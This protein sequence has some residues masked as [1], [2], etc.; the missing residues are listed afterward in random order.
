MINKK[1]LLA[2]AAQIYPLLQDQELTP[3]HGLIA[4]CSN[5]EVQQRLMSTLRACGA[6]QIHIACMKERYLRN[7]RLH[8]GLYQKSLKE[9]KIINFLDDVSVMKMLVGTMIPE[10]LCGQYEN[11]LLIFDESVGESS[12]VETAQGETK[13]FAAYARKNPAVIFRSMKLFKQ[14][15]ADG[16]ER[17]IVLMF[18]A[19]ACAWCEYL[20][21]VTEQQQVCQEKE[22][23][24]HLIDKWVEMSEGYL[25]FDLLG[26]NIGEMFVSYVNAHA[27]ILIGEVD[28]VD[29]AMA[30]AIEQG[31][32]IL[33]NRECFFV[34]EELLREACM[35]LRDAVS[36]LAIKRGLHEEGYLLCN[37]LKNGNYTTKLLVTNV[38]GYTSRPRFLKLKKEL[39]E[40]AESI[41]FRRERI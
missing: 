8:F 28:K 18:K 39:F 15:I 20:R 7:Y 26:R 25:D 1:V 32:G 37:N 23:L 16:A 3:E 17:K 31:K 21:E 19:T 13:S 24:F 29:S 36:F 33:E 4:L 38:F 41:G 6:A 27:D 14:N 9:E 30:Q 34:P 40:S 2:M 11:G 22:R 35:P 10:S 12:D 5:M